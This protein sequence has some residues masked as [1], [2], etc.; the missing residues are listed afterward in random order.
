MN[1][2]IWPAIYL[3]TVVP[4]SVLFIEPIYTFTV[5]EP[6]ELLAL[7]IFHLVVA[8]FVGVG[9]QGASASR[10]L[11]AHAPRC[12]SSMNYVGTR[13]S[14]RSTRLQKGCSRA[15]STPVLSVPW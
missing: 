11:D 10:G 4:W 3:G 1:F 5:A 15:K 14:P 8:V 6:Y 13:S 2:A 7:V 9:R 12:G